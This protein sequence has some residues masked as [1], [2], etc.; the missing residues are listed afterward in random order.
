MGLRQ[1]SEDC[2]IGEMEGDQTTVWLKGGI[3]LTWTG[4]NEK[5]SPVPGGQSALEDE[6]RD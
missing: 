6:G 4:L 1:L 2:D 3:D 5:L